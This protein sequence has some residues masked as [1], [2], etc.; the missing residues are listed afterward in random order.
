MEAKSFDVPPFHEQIAAYEDSLLG[1]RIGSPLLDGLVLAMVIA[2]GWHLLRYFNEENLLVCSLLLVS[3]FLLFAMIPTQWQRYFLIVQIPY[4]LIA[5]AGI[6]RF[7]LW[8]GKLF[9]R[10]P[11]WFYFP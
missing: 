10:F 3:A 7:W 5:G 8:G 11:E 6:H 9:E 1:G 2:G 4:S